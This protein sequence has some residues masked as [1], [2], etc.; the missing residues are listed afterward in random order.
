[1]VSPGHSFSALYNADAPNQNREIDVKH[2]LMWAGGVAL[3]VVVV[4]A[5]LKSG[6]LATVPGVG[7]YLTL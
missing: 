3:V 5:L 6:K 7:K 4:I 2:K 1:M